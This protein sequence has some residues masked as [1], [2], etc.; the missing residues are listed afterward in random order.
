[1]DDGRLVLGSDCTQ[2]QTRGRPRHP[3]GHF[4]LRLDQ[5]IFKAEAEARAT[6]CFS[7]PRVQ[8]IPMFQLPT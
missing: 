1:M 8:H 6:K 2:A 3:S 5:A 7:L 4:A